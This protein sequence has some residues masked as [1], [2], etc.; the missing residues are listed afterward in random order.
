MSQETKITFLG[1]G[2]STGVPVISCPCK[3]CTSDN[4]K[5]NR[6]RSSIFIQTPTTSVLVDTGPDLRQ[7][8]LREKITHADAVLY[9]HGHADHTVGMDE[10]RAFCWRREGRLPVYGSAETLEIM[11][12]MFPWAFDV[13]YQGRG[14]VRADGILFT[15]QFNIG[16][17]QVTPFQVHHGS[18]DTHG[19]KFLLPSGKSFIYVP[20]VKTLPDEHL[21]LLKGCDVHILDGLRLEPHSSHMTVSEACAL[22]Q[23]V[24]S[25]ETYLTHLSHDIDYETTPL[26]ENVFFSY[27]GL[28][29]HL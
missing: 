4:P 5:N 8:L 25:P 10:V 23:N 17:L 12:R 13:N 22:A 29:L 24:E 2:T 9:T 15:D 7:Q 11:T 18:V 6:T 14:Y 19:F 1:C 20:D 27:D 3:I 26:P 16:D 21:P 28:S